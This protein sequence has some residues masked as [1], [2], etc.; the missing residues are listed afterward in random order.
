MQTQTTSSIRVGDRLKLFPDSA[1]VQNE[2]LCIAGHDLASLAADYG[3]PLYVYDRSTLDASMAEYQSALKKYYPAPSRITYAGK[4]FL[5]K[6][7]A[8]WAQSQDLLVDCTGEGEIAIAV[9]A[10]VER[11]SILVHGVNKS[12]EDLTSAIE[13]AGT[14]V[15]DNLTELEHLHVILRERSDRRIS[16]V[17]SETLRSGSHRPDV[18]AQ[19]S[20][21]AVWLRLLPGVAVHTHH[22]H[23]QTGQHDSK[24]GMTPDEILEAAKFCKENNLPLQG[25]HFHQ[26]SN[27]RD[28]EPLLPAIELALDLAQ[29]MGFTSEWHFCPGGGWGVAY[30]EDELPNPSIESYVR[31]IAEAVVDGCQARGLSLPHLHLEP[32][33]SLVA[34][35]AVAVY[36]VGARKQR[37]EK[38]W[39]LT[40]GGMA[41]N[42]RF[43]LYGARY[44]C[45]PV[46]MTGLEASERV[47]IA[48]P[49]CESGDIVIEDLPMPIVEEGAWIAIPVSGAYHLSMSS[50]YNGA[51]RPA[52]LWLEEGNARLI[53]KRETV[54]DLLRNQL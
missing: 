30:H 20:D 35:A 39:L 27:F 18:L 19:D 17:T 5:C 31:G 40:D 3:T 4:A 9:A 41:D 14:M 2:S 44:S 52:V 15:V 45:L 25:I 8:A 7:I 26:G 33:R 29:R 12:V 22:T 46:S 51:R 37:G 23:T 43:A 48:G 49:F 1:S 21:I 13:H 34:R 50:N 38:T 36:R 16:D 54:Q 42:P 32:G 47:S 11:A 24:F 28:P 53:V 6:A 10:N